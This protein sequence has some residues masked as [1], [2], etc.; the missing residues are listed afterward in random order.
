LGLA[1]VKRIAEL[2]GGEVSVT[3]ELGHGTK[4]TLSLPAS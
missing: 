2:H 4:V 3:S 1:I